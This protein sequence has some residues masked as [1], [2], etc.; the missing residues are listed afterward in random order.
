M[1][2]ERDSNYYRNEV[3]DAH[4]LLED[5]VNTLL[6]M[7]FRIKLPSSFSNNYSKLDLLIDL[8]IIDEE[9][10]KS[11]QLFSRIRNQFIHVLG[12][13]RFTHLPMRLREQLLASQ[14]ISYDVV[15]DD[16]KLFEALKYLF[17]H[18][19]KDFMPRISKA[20]EKGTGDLKKYN[21]LKKSFDS[22]VEYICEKYPDEDRE[23]LLKR[24]ESE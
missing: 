1:S 3:L 12:C 19:M 5:N 11:F 17:E 13:T 7:A 22:L 21:N 20:M 4:L 10:R 23:K 14:K 18:L 15:E 6:E 8:K 2:E 24:F 9:Y 16:E